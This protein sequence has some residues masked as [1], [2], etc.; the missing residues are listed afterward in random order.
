MRY[1][2]LIIAVSAVVS[3][4]MLWRYYQVRSLG[5]DF[6]YQAPM[7]VYSAAEKKMVRGKFDQALKE[8]LRAREMLAAIPGIDLK[9]DFYYAIVNNAIGTIYLRRGIYGE[10]GEPATSGAEFGK[11]P[12]LIRRAREYFALS[13]AAIVPG[14]RQTGPMPNI[15][16]VCGHPDRERRRTRSSWSP[17]SATSGRCR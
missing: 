5:Q 14:W 10:K 3:I 1:V 9:T 7:R 11:H 4:V 13:A 16:L 12:E 17:L 6:R 15:S 8:Y 2:L